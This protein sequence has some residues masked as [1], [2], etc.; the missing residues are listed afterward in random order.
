MTS[1]CLLLFLNEST[2]AKWTRSASVCSRWN[3]MRS[4]TI[5]DRRNKI[6]KIYHTRSRCSY[7]CTW[8]HRYNEL[9][10]KRFNRI[11]SPF[12]LFVLVLCQT[13]MKSHILLNLASI[14]WNSHY[15][16]RNVCIDIIAKCHAHE[17]RL[18]IFVVCLFC[19]VRLATVHLSWLSHTHATAQQTQSIY[20]IQPS[21]RN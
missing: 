6:H 9:D 3:K 7:R 5:C 1:N 4:L 11:V 8:S 18:L 2:V 12:V 20:V 19:Y 17:H 21:D 14:E 13:R 16:E 15:Y 10:A